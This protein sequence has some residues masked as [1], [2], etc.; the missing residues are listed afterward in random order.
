MLE[1]ASGSLVPRPT[2][3]SSVSPRGRIPRRALRSAASMRSRERHRAAW[4]RSRDR[5]RSA[6][7]CRGLSG[8]EAVDLPRQVVLDMACGE[9]HGGHARGCAGRRGPEPI[10]PV[11]DHRPREFEIAAGDFG[12]PAEARA[13][14]AA[15]SLELGDRL[16]DRGCHGRRASPRF[17]RARSVACLTGT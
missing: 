5:G 10:E 2:T 9:E 11:A 15:R 12:S 8:G 17:S 16:G 7:R 4:A 1:L 13:R 3:S 14:L 6:A